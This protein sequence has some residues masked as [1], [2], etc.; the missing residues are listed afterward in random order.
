MKIKI[1]REIEVPDSLFCKKCNA[2]EEY[3]TKSAEYRAA[4]C[5]HF[6]SRVFATPK[7]G[8]D[9]VKCRECIDASLRHIGGLSK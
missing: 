9:F 6:N 1:N 8:W 2:K 7:S 4:N 3:D 5:C